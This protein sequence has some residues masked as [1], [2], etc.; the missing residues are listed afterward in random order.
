M[1]ILARDQQAQGGLTDDGPRAGMGKQQ[2]RGHWQAV[3]HSNLA[4]TT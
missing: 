3:K 1:Q 4:R 2:P